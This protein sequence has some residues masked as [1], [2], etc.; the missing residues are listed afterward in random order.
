LSSLVTFLEH[1]WLLSPRLVMC[2]S[3]EF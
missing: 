1:T 3:F 2:L